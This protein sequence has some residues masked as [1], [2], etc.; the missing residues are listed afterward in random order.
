M[1]C[2]ANEVFARFATDG[3]SVCVKECINSGG[4]NVNRWKVGH[5]VVSEHETDKNIVKHSAFFILKLYFFADLSALVVHAVHVFDD[6]LRQ[7]GNVDKVLARFVECFYKK[8]GC[9]AVQEDAFRNVQMVETKHNK[10]G[11]ESINDGG[12]IF[13]RVGKIS[14]VLKYFMFAFARFAAGRNDDFWIGFE[15]CG[16]EGVKFIHECGAGGNGASIPNGRRVWILIYCIH[17]F[18][19]IFCIFIRF[20]CIIFIDAFLQVSGEPRL[21]ATLALLI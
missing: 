4:S 10:V 19:C 16:N 9:F 6:G 12:L 8:F 3:L 17:I 2:Q 14:N 20:G 21:V 11:I 13:M 15:M 18:I 5:E 7:F 1:L